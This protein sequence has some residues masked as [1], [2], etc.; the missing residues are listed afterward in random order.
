MYKHV[1]D[2]TVTFI[3]K[4]LDVSVFL[5]ILSYIKQFY[6]NYYWGDDG[7]NHEAV[8]ILDLS[9]PCGCCTLNYRETIKFT[10]LDDDIDLIGKILERVAQGFLLAKK[11]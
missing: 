5:P 8:I 7:F 4:Y 10:R 6:I 11:D 2:K 1:P 3:D 9:D